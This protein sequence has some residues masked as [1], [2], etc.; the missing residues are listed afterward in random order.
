MPSAGPRL[1]ARGLR[2]RFGARAVLDAIDFTVHAGEIA[3]IEGPSGGGKSTL[4]RALANLQALVAG[5]LRVDGA[6]DLPP[7]AY[8]RR[9]A[10]VP[11]APVMFPGAV[12]DNLRAGPRLH[13]ATLTDAQVAALLRQVELDPT[14]A[15]RPAR[16]LSGGEQQRVAIARA[17]ANQPAVLLFDEPTSALDPRSAGAILALAR[18]CAADGGGVVVVTHAREQAERLA[19]THYACADGRLQ[20]RSAT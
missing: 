4:L 10:Y 11:Q 19:G 13:G 17:L 8:R 7:E 15:T 9:V 14:L 16:E 6:A 3:V 2:V 20:R 1:E 5:E 18:R 12:A